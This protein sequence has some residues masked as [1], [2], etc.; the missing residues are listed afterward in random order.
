MVALREEVA[1]GLR[2]EGRHALAERALHPR[3]HRHQLGAREEPEIARERPILQGRVRLGRLG[4]RHGRQRTVALLLEP[5][6]RVGAREFAPRDRDFLLPRQRHEQ[7]V[8]QEPGVLR[9][10]DARGAGALRRLV[11]Q[12]LRERRGGRGGPRATAAISAGVATPDEPRELRPSDLV[13]FL[14]GAHAA[15]PEV[16]RVGCRE[17][18]ARLAQQRRHRAEGRREPRGSRPA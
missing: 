8:A 2:R 11:A 17:V 10:A 5:E 15:H 9:L 13:L 4:D 6:R 1:R 12:P 7:H 16:A 18:D 3:L 14:E